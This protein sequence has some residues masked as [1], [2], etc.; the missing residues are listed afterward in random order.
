MPPSPLHHFAAALPKVELHVHLEGAILPATVLEL[1]RRHA[2]PLPAQDEA[3]LRQW[4]RF[5][6]FRHFIDVYLALQ[7]LLRTPEDFDLITYDFGREMARQHI[8]YAEVTFTPFTHLWQ[9]KGLTPDDIIAGLEAG[10]QRAQTE[11]GVAIAWVIDI[12]RNLSFRDGVYTGA[13]SDP[14]VEMALAWRDRG[15]VALGLGGNEV[16]APPEP[17]AHAFAAARAG[18]LHS[19]PHAGETVGPES[20]WGSLRALGAERIGHG[21]RSSEDPALVAHLIEQQIPLEINPTSNLCLG[22]YADY[23]AHPLR[24]LWDLGAYVTVN[25][26]DPP[27]FNT[28]LNQ[29]YGVLIDQFGF[30]PAELEQISLNALRASFLPPARKAAL[31][32]D[33]RRQFAQLRQMFL[34]EGR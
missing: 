26:D 14:T 29:E 16:G 20:V 5:T 12:P 28:T 18:G 13:A 23:A 34:G 17:F 24:R 31:E 11:F 19:A 4:Y 1:A 8:H 22:V 3:G 25:S 33:F 10:R 27:L 6:N 21:V 9:D 2:L 7:N 32:E 30:G 15:V